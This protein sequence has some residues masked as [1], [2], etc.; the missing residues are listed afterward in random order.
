[1]AMTLRLDP[2]RAAELRRAANEDGRSMQ[3]TAIRAID[4]YLARRGRSSHITELA[5]QAAIDY[6]ET[7]RRLGE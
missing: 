3:Q 5:R 7:L 1:M 4:E 6:P 2:E